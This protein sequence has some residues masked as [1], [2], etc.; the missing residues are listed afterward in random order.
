[1]YWETSCS[2]FSPSLPRFSTVGK[3]A[4]G[5]GRGSRSPG[6]KYSPNAYPPIP[7]H[8]S[9]ATA[10]STLLPGAAVSAPTPRSQP[11]SGPKEVANNSPTSSTKPKPFSDPFLRDPTHRDLE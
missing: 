4:P 11:S 1:M 9:F 3:L 6:D 7:Y 2:W 8:M 5:G 10:L